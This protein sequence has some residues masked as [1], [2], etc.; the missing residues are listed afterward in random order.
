MSINT[1]IEIFFSS[2]AFNRSS[3]T[4]RRVVSVEWCLRLPLWNISVLSTV[5]RVF[6]KAVHEQVYHHLVMNNILAPRQSGF[7]SLQSAV[8]ALL[9]LASQWCFNIDKGM[10]SGVVFLDLKKAFDTVDHKLLL[11]K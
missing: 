5:S 3:V 4:K 6:E 10:M 1:N 2:I 8:T 7:R 9:V 11:T